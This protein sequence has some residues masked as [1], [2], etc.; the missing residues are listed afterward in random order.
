MYK[1]LQAACKKGGSSGRLCGA[2]MRFTQLFR[3]LTVTS[4]TPSSSYCSG[5]PDREICI[6]GSGYDS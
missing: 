6:L 1:V 2:V 3:M 5:C 4:F